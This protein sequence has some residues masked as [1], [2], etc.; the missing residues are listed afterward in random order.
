MTGWAA[1][2]DG[3]EENLAGYRALLTDDTGPMPGLWPPP[4]L[5]GVPM[6]PDQAARAR[7]LLAEAREL[8]GR[9]VARRAE[10]PALRG[11]G[12]NRRTTPHPSFL[13]EL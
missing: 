13:T 5:A 6:P 9:L 8:E 2:L 12:P 1:A 7:R 3:F 4:E 11:G 10:L